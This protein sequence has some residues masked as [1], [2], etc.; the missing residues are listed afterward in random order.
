MYPNN[1][2][3][4]SWLS[5]SSG[6]LG[7]YYWN[8]TPY[9][10]NN[11]TYWAAD[12]GNHTYYG[13]VYNTTESYPNNIE[14]V[15]TFTHNN[16]SVLVTIINQVAFRDKT[17]KSVII[18]G[19]VT[20]IGSNAFGGCKSLNSITIN[21]VNAPTLETNA[22]GSG[23]STAGYNSGTTNVLYVPSNATGYDT[24]AW[25]NNLLNES[26]GKFTLSKTLE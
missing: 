12:T 22:F 19:T 26:Y 9:T 2:D 11:V 4:S 21:R 16:Q 20:K 8:H 5:R 13:I 25:T 6:Y 15:N 10:I 3:F 1:I 7:Y 24:V 18:P 14:I 17:I 23:T